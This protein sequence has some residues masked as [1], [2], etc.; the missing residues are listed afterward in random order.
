MEL[1]PGMSGM[2]GGRARMSQMVNGMTPIQAEPSKVSIVSRSGIKGRS[3][4]SSMRQCMNRSLPQDWCIIGIPSG[5]LRISRRSRSVGWPLLML[6]FY[7]CSW[8]GQNGI[9]ISGFVLCG[10]RVGRVKQPVAVNDEFVGVTA[11]LKVYAADPFVRLSG[12]DGLRLI[13]V[14]ERACQR[15]DTG[16]R[17]TFQAKSGVACQTRRRKLHSLRRIA[18]AFIYKS[19]ADDPAFLIFIESDARA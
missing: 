19:Q 15:D 16:V 3:S 1:M 14:I 7:P 6:L 10:L 2:N 13:P 18:F 5:R 12:A 8:F 4:F 11:R 17:I 9:D